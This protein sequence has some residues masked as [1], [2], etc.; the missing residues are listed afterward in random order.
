MKWE[1][2]FT[3]DDRE[4]RLVET[5]QIMAR[6]QALLVEDLEW[7]DTAQVFTADG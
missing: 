5:A 7:L 4:T 1:I 2:D 6:L 3:V